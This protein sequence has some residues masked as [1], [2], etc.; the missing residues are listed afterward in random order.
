MKSPGMEKFG[1]W[2]VNLFKKPYM[3]GMDI[4]W[5]HTMEQNTKLFKSVVFV[6]RQ[7]WVLSY[8]P[9]AMSSKCSS[10]LLQFFTIDD[11]NQAGSEDV[12][13]L[14]AVWLDLSLLHLQLTKG[15]NL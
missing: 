10:L 7:A 1:G 2:R 14:S 15:S 11:W 4:F 3:E 8:F 6:V 9:F 13:R 5:N 12:Y